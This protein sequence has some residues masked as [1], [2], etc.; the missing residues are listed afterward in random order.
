MY[1]NCF[2]V[3]PSKSQFSVRAKRPN[4]IKHLYSTCHINNSLCH[5][6]IKRTAQATEGPRCQ[7][8]GS[9]KDLLVI[10]RTDVLA[11]ET[12]V[13]QFKKRPS[14]PAPMSAV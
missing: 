10:R 12:L 6:G 9:P 2:S 1:S 5:T 13:F 11:Q 3:S 8:G 14:E 7:K 4:I